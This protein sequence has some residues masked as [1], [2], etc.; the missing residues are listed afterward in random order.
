MSIKDYQLYFWDGEALA[1]GKSRIIEPSKK[2]DI[3][4]T[5]PPLYLSVAMSG[6][7]GDATADAQV[8]L[9]TGDA[10]GGSDMRPNAIWFIPRERITVGGLVLVV[11]LPPFLRHY[12]QLELSDLA[13]VSGGTIGAT[14]SHDGDRTN[15]L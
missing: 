13:G 11:P 3:G 1:N 6:Q 14:Y 8:K 15:M 9:S 2:S 10:L 5:Y 7:T 12:H 4:K